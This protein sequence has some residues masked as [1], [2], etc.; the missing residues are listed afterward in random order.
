MGLARCPCDGSLDE[1]QYAR[2]VNDLIEAMSSRPQ[3]LLTGLADRM[4]RLAREQR[5]EEAGWARDRHD[6][7][8][9][10]L[11]R[12]WEWDALTSAGW[13]E[14]EHADGT[15][16][17]VDHG[18]LVET[19]SP[20]SPPRLRPAISSPGGVPPVAPSVESAEEAH[21]IWRWIESSRVRVVECTGTFAYPVHRVEPL[22][23]LRDLAA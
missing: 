1:Q 6:A 4:G 17:V 9:R 23:T 5:Y 8:V 10:A 3:P 11:Q 12:R 13:L 2:V 7:L 16:A 15:I 14:L 21:L 22:T 20:G 18:V 19:R